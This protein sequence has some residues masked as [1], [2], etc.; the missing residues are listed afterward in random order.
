MERAVSC[1]AVAEGKRGPGRRNYMIRKTFA[2]LFAHGIRRE[3]K[4]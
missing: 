3:W 2:Q 4:F 1:I